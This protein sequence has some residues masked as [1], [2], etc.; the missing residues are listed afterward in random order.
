M[1][2]PLNPPRRAVLGLALCFLAAFGLYLHGLS[3]AW[4]PDDSAETITAGATLGLQHPPGYPL[5]SLLG[6]CAV[7]LGPGPAPF[8]INA[9]AAFFAA[10]SVA[11]GAALLF[12]LGR[13]VAPEAQEAPLAGLALGGAALLAVTQTLW[14]QAG[15]AKGGIYTLNLALTLGALLAVLRIRRCTLDGP[16]ELLCGPGSL[17]C[18]A[19]RSVAMGG[20]LLGLGFANHWTSQVVLLPGFAWLLAEA[21]WRR[22]AWP[23]LRQALRL[24]LVA[25]LPAAAGLALYL[26]L[27]LRGRQGPLLVW[28]D[29]STWSG[30]VWMF[31]RG[32]Y[33][34]V[35]ANKTLQSWLALM[36]HIGADMVQDWTWP[37]LLACGA[38]WVLLARRRWSLALGLLALPL[39]L[40]VAVATKANPPADS[41]FIVDP[42]LV[43]LQVG[44]GLGLAGWA[45][46]LPGQAWL[47]LLLL[48]G[49]ADLGRHQWA[50]AEHRWDTLGYDYT[51]NLLLGAPKDALLFCEGDSNTAG[52][53]VPHLAEGRRQDLAVMATVLLD[54]PWY[55]ASLLK[56]DPRLKLPGPL[57]PPADMAWME[58]ANAPRPVAWTNSY[59]KGWVDEAHLLHRGLLLVQTARAKPWDAAS[60][61][62]NDVFPAYA[63]RG[64]FAPGA[65]VMDPLSQR[66]VRDNYV[67][68]QARLA[69]AW[70]DLRQWRPAR[71]IFQR[72]G[73]WRPGWAA[74]WVQ[75]GNAAYF[76]RDWDGAGLDWKR[77][78]AED[79]A[80]AEAWSDLGLLALQQGRPDDALNLARKAL[81]LNPGL[82]SAQQLQQQ[83]LARSLGRA[84]APAAAS[85]SAGLQ[86]A[87]TA[88]Q[89]GQARQWAQAL[90][91]YDQALRLGFDNAVVERNR[92][93]MLG[94]LQRPAEAAEA[95][96][97]AV[98]MNGASADLRKLYGLFLYNSGKRADGLKQ[99]QEG[100][101]L[102]PKDPEIQRLLKQAQG[103]P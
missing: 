80:S 57:T 45:T 86:A 84:P 90:A 13:E 85:A 89:L 43:P 14:F 67:E 95:L 88:D 81:D 42:Y 7:L 44:F 56:Q 101:R 28:G 17:G 41:Y 103:T 25:G 92:G 27:P 2:L 12:T 94:Q 76:D 77:A 82:A 58:K 53:F 71:A 73:I 68:A 60:L 99:F 36:G 79:P 16:L 33:A 38:G 61:R 69:Q 51:N 21:R 97:K 10:L 48:A 59:T 4:H 9:M 46:L 55:H 35:E 64:V 66:L 24:A 3:P 34:G 6:R 32:Q 1:T 74:P 20:L 23:S 5:H 49:A 91:A 37:G 93:V 63:L 19:P 8:N 62:A 50:L 11:L 72:L 52:P 102:D 30:F 83:A 75:A 26:Y 47:G 96:A 98:A 78:A 22:Q 18:A 100:A 31:T 70:M 40:A 87:K 29:A 54:Y 39:L 15:I 65:R